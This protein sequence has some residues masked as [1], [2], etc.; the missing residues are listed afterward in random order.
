VNQCV[1]TIDRG[2]SSSVA[3]AKDA[4]QIQDYEVNWPLLVKEKGA[5][6]RLSFVDYRVM[7]VEADQGL[8]EEGNSDQAG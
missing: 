7:K 4:G 8:A 1:E 3:V 2:D 5:R 6:Y